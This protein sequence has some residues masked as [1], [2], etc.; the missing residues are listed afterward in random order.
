M[1]EQSTHKLLGARDEIAQNCLY[2][3]NTNKVQMWVLSCSKD[4]Y[5][6]LLKY[7]RQTDESILEVREH[8]FLTFNT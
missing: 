1:K 5:F 2:R 7:S 4:W 8:I 6:N 3:I